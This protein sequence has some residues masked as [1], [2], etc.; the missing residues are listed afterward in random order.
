MAVTASTLATKLQIRIK[1]GVDENGNDVIANYSLASGTRSGEIV[2]LGCNETMKV[3]VAQQQATAI[4]IIRQS[5][6]K[7]MPN[8][9]SGNQLTIAIPKGLKVVKAR[10]TDINGQ[11]MAEQKIT[12]G[13]NTLNV[14][15][16]PGMYFL[17]IMGL[18]VNYTTKIVIN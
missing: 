14:N 4:D 5:E 11:S 18:E 10:F 3:K 6:I 8:P 17:G 15:L 1:T 7:V 9:L 2:L 16:P 13:I 12:D